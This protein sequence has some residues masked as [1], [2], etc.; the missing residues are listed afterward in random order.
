MKNVLFS[1]Q[2]EHFLLKFVQLIQ[3]VFLWLDDEAMYYR[4]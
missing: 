3:L 2:S 1:L 4:E